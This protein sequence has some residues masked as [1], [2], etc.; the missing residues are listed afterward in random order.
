MRKGKRYT[1]EYKKKIIDLYKSRMSLSDISR[2]YGR[3]NIQNDE[4]CS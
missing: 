2:E 3:K 4:K 1:A